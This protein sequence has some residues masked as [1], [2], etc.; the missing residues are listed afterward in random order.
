MKDK[1]KYGISQFFNFVRGS[2]LERTSRPVYALVFL[3]PFILLYELGT[4]LIKTNALQPA[5]FSHA[6]R[7]RVVAFTWMQS[8]LE[9]LGFGSKFRG[10]LRH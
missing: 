7:G 10:L 4:I 5:F 6:W 9:Y 2:Y 3:L 1:D 8:F